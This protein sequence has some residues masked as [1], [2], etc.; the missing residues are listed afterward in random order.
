MTQKNKDLVVFIPSRDGPDKLSAT[1]DM[2]V[3]TC[4]SKD[5][6]DVLCVIDDDQETL[7]QPV[8]NKYQD[9]DF[10]I[11]SHKSSNYSNIMDFHFDFIENT[12][13][14]FNWWVTDDFRGL[15]KGWDE[16]IIC[17]KNIFYDEYYTLFTNNL[18]SRNINAMSN[19]FTKAVEPVDGYKKPLLTD[20]SLLIYHYHEMLPIC[21]K[22]WRLAIKKANDALGG[23]DHVF[24]NA[25]LAHLLS[26]YYNY[27]RS[28][29][30]D[31]YYSY[32]HDSGNAG[33]K[34]YKN[35]LTRDE[36]FFQW[37]RNENFKSL[38]PVVEE[39]AD[40]IWQ[41]YR[42]RMDKPRGI[43]RYAKR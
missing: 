31:F 43:G 24:L 6:F 5:N 20:P 36:H 2:L 14:Y 1:L 30:V 25:S 11:L 26:K 8:K 22:N 10:K 16:K 13:Y 29:E 4:S 37:A 15:T 21:T 38:L 17:K 33:K 18:M 12:D 42:D 35:G 34:V 7:Y 23:T 32:I 28:I 3:E 27:S 9:F 40:E 39:I 19:Q 41:H